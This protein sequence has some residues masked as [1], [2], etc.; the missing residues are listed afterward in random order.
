MDNGRTVLAYVMMILGFIGFFL[1]AGI[2][3]V[4]DGWNNLPSSGT[5][6]IIGSRLYIILPALLAIFC[7]MFELVA[8]YLFKSTK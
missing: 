8:L 3:V 7:L 1:T 5:L 4:L 6:Q 2:Y